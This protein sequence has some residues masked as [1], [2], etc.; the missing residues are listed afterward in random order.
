MALWDILKKKKS[1]PKKKEDK[2]PKVEKPK[3]EKKEGSQEKPKTTLRKEKKIKGGKIAF[4]VLKSSHITEKATDLSEKN[5]YIFKVYSKANKTEIKKA[6]ENLFG[7]EVLS[8]RTLK[9]QRK[10]RRL[11][12]SSGWRKGYKKAIVRIKEGQKIE[13]LGK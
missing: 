2:K 9:V 8:V 12:R 4:R 3:V 7:V 13:E 5:Q 10:K 1:S 6:I 11:R